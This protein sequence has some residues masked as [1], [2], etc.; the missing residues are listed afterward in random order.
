MA[1]AAAPA[2]LMDLFTAPNSVDVEP[3]SQAQVTTLTA[4]RPVGREA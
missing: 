4:D 2:A 1:T 3:R